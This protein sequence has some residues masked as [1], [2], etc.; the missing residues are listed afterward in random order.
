MIINIDFPADK[1]H[2][3]LLLYNLLSPLKPSRK[4][5]K[6]CWFDGDFPKEVLAQVTKNQCEE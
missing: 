3:Y 4:Q 1:M 2:Y 5:D 6:P